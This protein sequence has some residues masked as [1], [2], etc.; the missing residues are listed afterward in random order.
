MAN[1]QFITFLHSWRKQ[2]PALDSPNF[3]GGNFDDALLE[4]LDK[5][6]LDTID[7][8]IADNPHYI[9]AV[10]WCGGSFLHY[11]AT[12]C[13]VESVKKL[14]ELG[15]DINFP[16]QRYGNT[17]LE[18]AAG[19]NS[20]DN[21]NYLLKK[22]AL[23][24]LSDSQKSPLFSAIQANNIEI[25]KTILSSKINKGQEFGF[26]QALNFSLTYGK[27]E[28]AELLLNHLA[29]ED[30]FLKRKLYRMT[31]RKICSFPRNLI[32][33]LPILNLRGDTKS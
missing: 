30:K 4:A 21:F 10:A 15:F 16:N 24:D 22:N 12:R 19:S 29:G 27:R 7:N 5:A 23:I 8:V 9:D 13:P 20:S 26:H 25:V 14:V 18:A 33:Y 11:A 3:F 32:Y 1:N 28:C 6:D 2:K 31:M 17:P